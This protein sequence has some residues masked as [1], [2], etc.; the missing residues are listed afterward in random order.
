MITLQKTI[1]LFLSERIPST[2]RSYY[3]VFKRFAGWVG[4]DRPMD[5]ITAVH[6]LEFAQTIRDDPG[7][8]SPATFNKYVKDIRALFNWAI[9]AAFIAPP[10]PAAP[11]KL[12]RQ[13]RE[14]PREKAMPD[15][16]YD[17]LLDF[18]KWL[19]RSYA[20][21][22]FLG[23]TGCRIGGAAGLKWT[24]VDFEA[25]LAIVTE[26]GDNTHP[27]F[28]GETCARAL[29]HWQ[30]VQVRA[31]EYVFSMKGGAINNDSLGQ[32]FERICLKAGI[33]QWGPHSLRH[34]KGYQLADNKVPVSIASKALNHQNVM[35]TLEH[36][37]PKDW[38]RVREA[39]AELT[40]REEEPLKI[41][42]P[43]RKID[44]R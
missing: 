16:S 40:Y 14:I 39:M 30:S 26:K 28:F 31:G 2:R 9:K 44:G 37:Y 24:N 20:L 32:H 6:V 25:Q 8:N 12:T 35:T 42:T 3:Y 36:Y 1:D 34:R 10:S 41:L 21:V 11:L 13:R 29:A 5:K 18:T 23:D 7:I 27:V 38:E 22:L 17:R 33:G 15:T 43:K 19:P 4:P